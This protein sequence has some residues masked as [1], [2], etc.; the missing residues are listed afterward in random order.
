MRQITNI[1]SLLVKFFVFVFVKNTYEVKVF[2][3]QQNFKNKY[4]KNIQDTLA[5]IFCYLFKR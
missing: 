4:K 2:I 3:S 1:L 5:L